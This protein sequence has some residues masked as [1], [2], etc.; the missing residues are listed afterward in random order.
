MNMILCVAADR[1]DTQSLLNIIAEQHGEMSLVNLSTAMHKLA[2][3]AKEDVRLLGSGDQRLTV[4]HTAIH[5]ELQR[6]VDAG[7]ANEGGLGLSEPL[8]ESMPRCWSTIAWA[9][10]TLQLSGIDASYTF[11][12][13]GRL[14]MVHL[15]SFKPLELTNLLWGFAKMKAFMPALFTATIRHTIA[16]LRP[17]SSSNMSTLIWAVVTAQQYEPATVQIIVE[18]FARRLPSSEVK[19]VELTN[20]MWGLATAKI[21][22]KAFVLF[23]VGSRALELISNFQLQELS[24]TCWS[25]ARLHARYDRFFAGVCT[26]LVSSYSLLQQIHPQGMANLL[27]AF[28]KQM[29]M[30]S[31]AAEEIMTALRVLIARCLPLLK[32]L[33]PQEFACVFRALACMGVKWRLSREADNLFSS[34]AVVGLGMVRRFSAPQC[35]DLLTAFSSF[36]QSG[37]G[38]QFPE[39]FA[40][41]LEAVVQRCLDNVAELGSSGRPASHAVEV[42]ARTVCFFGEQ[43]CHLVGLL[44]QLILCV[45]PERFSAEG[46][47]MLATLCRLPTQDVD[48]ERVRQALSVLS[49]ETENSLGG[50]MLGPDAFRAA[51]VSSGPVSPGAV[52]GDKM[53]G[54][55][56]NEGTWA[57]DWAGGDEGEGAYRNDLEVEVQGRHYRPDLSF[58]ATSSRAQHG[59]CGG[60][61]CSGGY[62]RFAPAPSWSAGPPAPVLFE[63]RSGAPMVSGT[64]VAGA[65]TILPALPLAAPPASF[66]PPLAGCG[67]SSMGG[68]SS[69]SLASPQ[70]GFGPTAFG[71]HSMQDQGFGQS[72]VPPPQLQVGFGPTPFDEQGMQDQGF[73]QARSFA[74]QQQH[75]EQQIEFNQ[76]QHQ[77]TQQQ[78]QQLLQQQQQQLHEFGQQQEQQHQLQQMEQQLQQQQ[79]LQQM[80]QHLRQQH[81]QQQQQMLRLQQQQQQNLLEQQERQ[82]RQWSEQFQQPSGQQPP[83]LLEGLQKITL[84]QRFAQ[85]GP[86]ASDSQLVGQAMT[87]PG[88][89]Q[90]GARRQT[91]Q[92]PKYGFAAP[93][94]RPGGGALDGRRA[95]IDGPDAAAGG[96]PDA[97]GLA[98]QLAY[99]GGSYNF[100]RNTE[101]ND[102]DCRRPLA[103]NYPSAH[104]TVDYSP[105]FSQEGG[106]KEPHPGAGAIVQELFEG[107]ADYESTLQSGPIAQS[108]FASLQNTA[109]WPP[110]TDD[111]AVTGVVIKNTFLEAAAALDDDFTMYEN[112]K[113]FQSEPV[114]HKTA[115]DF[116][117][118]ATA[119]ASSSAPS[120]AADGDASRAA[121]TPAHMDTVLSSL[122]EIMRSS[123]GGACGVPRQGRRP[124]GLPEVEQGLGVPKRKPPGI[125][126]VVEEE[127]NQPVAEETAQGSGG[128]EAWKLNEPAY[129]VR[130][131]KQ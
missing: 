11:Q 108:G 2:R 16:D 80:Q 3:L 78:Q 41:F 24:I 84:E 86:A 111:V 5:I 66:P 48:I 23:E 124:E 93:D 72:R 25:F 62:D 96:V 1:G 7:L 76:L 109:A 45:R 19:P 112:A 64:V 113:R 20:L 77:H 29:A 67:M 60:L 98:G 31:A 100:T 129:I 6:Q 38:G 54:R 122:L 114:R 44:A 126:R 82:L 65:T 118:V 125:Q 28:E 105:S 55:R 69:M 15:T 12:L 121:P 79:Q 10:G 94:T 35:V 50:P 104:T 34:A 87:Q 89:W 81:E 42:A 32:Q 103:S 57:G 88:S 85:T 90:V 22:P 97:R 71:E 83:Q 75:Q 101:A 115:L 117:S 59:G 120:T 99:V 33:K 4:L 37:V 53:G 51:A 36:I 68:M 116:N 61:P 123:R 58:V 131:D 30:G 92:P 91:G 8:D 9:Y 46:Q 70:G 110:Q 128:G 39:V 47:R 95:V 49:Y 52:M 21:H 56:A 73:G 74:S 119:S 106:H 107:E 130:R 18:E 14:A 43:H 63:G 26:H 102:E 17:F 13:I 127:A 40:S 27:W